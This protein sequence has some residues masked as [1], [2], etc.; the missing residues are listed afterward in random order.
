MELVMAL[1]N[2]F[3]DEETHHYCDGVFFFAKL[4]C[5]MPFIVA[6]ISSVLRNL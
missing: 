2:I 1:T 5:I 6:G 3:N 4:N